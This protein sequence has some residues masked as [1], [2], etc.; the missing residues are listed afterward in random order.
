MDI[1]VQVSW[2][3]HMMCI[4]VNV[5]NVKRVYSPIDKS[6]VNITLNDNS[7]IDIIQQDRDTDEFKHFD[8]MDVD[9]IKYSDSWLGK[10]ITVYHAINLDMMDN[11]DF[12]K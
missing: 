10:N 12:E 8:F 5:T 2:N 1:Q 9:F 7:T 3:D 6:L 4:D 11:I